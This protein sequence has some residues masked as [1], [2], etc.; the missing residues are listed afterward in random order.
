[1]GGSVTKYQKFK[2]SH[3]DVVRRNCPLSTRRRRPSLSLSYRL[4]PPSSPSSELRSSRESE[5]E[6]REKESERARVLDTFVRICRPRSESQA[7][8]EIAL[9]AFPRD[10]GERATCVTGRTF[11]FARIPEKPY[12]LGNL[13]HAR[14]DMF[15]SIIMYG[16]NFADKF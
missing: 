4:A 3:R 13:L 9:L 5:R 2:I 15:A 16:F 6:G 12:A 10:L 14:P 8:L 7:R 11:L 1:M